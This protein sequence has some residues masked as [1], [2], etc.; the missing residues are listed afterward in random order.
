MFKFINNLLSLTLKVFIT[1]IVVAIGYTY[2]IP[3][4]V[5]QIIPAIEKLL[6]N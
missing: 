3:L 6:G 4:I 2:A 1:L 5:E